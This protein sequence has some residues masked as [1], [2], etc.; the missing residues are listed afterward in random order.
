[1]LQAAQSIELTNKV[2]AKG[3]GRKKNQENKKGTR[4]V[5]VFSGLASGLVGVRGSEVAAVPRGG[6]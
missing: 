4:E 3:G 6:G 1:M 2:T 5:N